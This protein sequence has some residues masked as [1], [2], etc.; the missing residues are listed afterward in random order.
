MAVEVAQSGG[1]G[2]GGLM[3]VSRRRGRKEI[4]ACRCS[5][6]GSMRLPSMWSVL[7]IAGN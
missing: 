4:R 2:S 6:A 1:E 7:P 5:H 3:R